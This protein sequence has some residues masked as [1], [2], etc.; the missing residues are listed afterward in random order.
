MN[1]LKIY[2][3]TRKGVAISLQE[4]SILTVVTIIITNCRKNSNR[5]PAAPSG[6]GYSSSYE[7]S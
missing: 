3:V 5:K 2:K 7:L 4:T 6:I 1:K